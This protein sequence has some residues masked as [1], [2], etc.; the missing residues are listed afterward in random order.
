MSPEVNTAA[1]ILATLMENLMLLDGQW[2]DTEY[3]RGL[4]T[5]PML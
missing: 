4:I 2:T 1:E 5:E 3:I